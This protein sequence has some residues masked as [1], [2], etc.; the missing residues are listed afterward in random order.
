MISPGPEPPIVVLEYTPYPRRGDPHGV[1]SGIRQCAAYRR[2]QRLHPG[3]ARA[4]NSRDHPQT[5]PHSIPAGG[6]PLPVRTL[7]CRVALRVSAM[8]ERT[9]HDGQ[10]D[11]FEHADVP[12]RIP[13][14]DHDRR[15]HL[16]PGTTVTTAAPVGALRSTCLTSALRRKRANVRNHAVIDQEQTEKS[17]TV[18]RGMQHHLEFQDSV[19]HPI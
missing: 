11:L 13:H 7:T 2:L 14:R 18:E 5:T 3:G 12:F 6:Q 9:C 15:T 16:H 10:L 19:R 1:A 8:L 17:A 4:G